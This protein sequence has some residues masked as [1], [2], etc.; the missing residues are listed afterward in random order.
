MGCVHCVWENRSDLILRYKGDIIEIKEAMF[1]FCS[2][3][4]LNV[5]FSII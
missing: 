3:S 2:T 4:H 1:T 5:S